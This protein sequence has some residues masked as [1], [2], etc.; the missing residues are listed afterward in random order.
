MVRT[1]TI[2]PLAASSHNKPTSLKFFNR[3]LPY[4][5]PALWNGILKD[6]HQLFH[7]LNPPPNLTYPLLALSSATFHSR[8]KTELFKLSNPVSTP[9]PRHV[10]HHH[11]LQP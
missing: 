4:A 2:E 11:R 9:A 10:R 7:P 6:L 5:A 8:L 3:S 1:L